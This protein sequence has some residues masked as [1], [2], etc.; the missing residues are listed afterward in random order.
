MTSPPPPLRLAVVDDYEIVVKGIAEMLAPFSDRAV[1]VELDSQMPVASDVDLV[2]CD[3]FGYVPG[4]G[5]DLGDLVPPG[6]AKVVAY[7][8]NFHPDA[9][10]RATAQGVAGCLSK[11]LPAPELVAALEAIHAGEHVVRGPETGNDTEWVEGDYPGRAL[12]LSPREAEVLALIAKGLSNQ[13]MAEVLY[14]S[15]NSIKTYVRTAY[16][17]IGV[18][19]R[20]QAVVWAMQHGLAAQIQRETLAGNLLP[21]RPE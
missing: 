10:A 19:R 14:L 6:K 21:G 17:K 16:G 13:E 8:W 1:V 2:L 12:G 20:S 5:I 4:E 7:T 18:S 9:I 3:L 11:S 15:I